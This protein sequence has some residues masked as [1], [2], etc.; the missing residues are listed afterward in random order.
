MVGLASGY[1]VSALAGRCPR[2][3]LPDRV[4]SPFPATPGSREGSPLPRPLRTGRE[5][6]P[7]PGSSRANAP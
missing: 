2:I 1:S 5:S 4:A 6:F 7:S 3:A